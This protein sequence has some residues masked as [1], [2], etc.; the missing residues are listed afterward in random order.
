M[1]R[2]V[3]DECHQ[4]KCGE[5]SHRPILRPSGREGRRAGLSSTSVVNSLRALF[6]PAFAFKLDGWARGHLL[7]NT[8]TNHGDTIAH[9]YSS[10]LRTRVGQRRPAVLTAISAK[11]VAPIP[12][13]TAPSGAPTGTVP[14]RSAGTQGDQKSTSH[15]RMGCDHGSRRC[16]GVRVRR[17]PCRVPLRP[18]DRG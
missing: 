6:P 12:A 2:D 13:I 7:P 9:R 15:V 10:K 4:V 5:T 3:S 14:R 8:T 18:P 16:V 17:N 1:P 11:E